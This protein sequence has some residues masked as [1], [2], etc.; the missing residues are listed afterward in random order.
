MKVLSKQMTRAVAAGA[1]LLTTLAGIQLVRRA[2]QRRAVEAL[3]AATQTR[4][5][6]LSAFVREH[7]AALEMLAHNAGTN[8][9][10][11]AA[12]AGQVNAATLRDIFQNESYWQPFREA[13]RD[14]YLALPGRK[15]V[16]IAGKREMDL[17]A[18][19]LVERASQS[20][21]VTS[22]LLEVGGWV[23]AVVAVPVTL[24]NVPQVPVLLLLQPFDA[25]A[26][27]KLVERTGEAVVMSNGQQALLGA[28]SAAQTALLKSAIG[29]ETVSAGQVLST[30]D[31]AVAAVP[32]GN[33]LW[34]LSHVAEA[35]GAAGAVYAVL[36][37]GTGLLGAVI[38]LLL[39][40]GMRRR[41]LV[42]PDG[43][44]I[45]ATVTEVSSGSR[46]V[47]LKRLG[48]GGAAEV[49]LAVS[50]G[51]RGFRRP[52]VVKRLRPE[53]SRD[54]EAM[55]QFTDE[56]TLA[57]SLVH[58][59]I[60]PIYD[61]ARYADQYFLVEEYIVGRDFGRL[62]RAAREAKMEVPAQVAAHVVCETLKALDYAHNKRDHDG[63]P[64]GIVH[65]DVSPEN[66]MVNTRG[67]VQLLDFGVL[68]SGARGPTRRKKE[69]GE[70]RGNLT[71]MAPEQAKGE[72]VDARAD[73]Y[74]LGLV[75]YYGLTGESLYGDE[76]TGYDL[77]MNAA[78]GPGLR[79]LAKL[80][81]LPEPY[82]HILR[83]ALAPNPEHRYQSATAFLEALAPLAGD[84]RPR[85]G[86]M[87]TQLFG[88]ELE[89]ERHQLSGTAT[90]AKPGL[91]GTREFEPLPP[92][93]PT[94]RRIHV[95][96]GDPIR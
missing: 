64:L 49:H 92:R 83:K 42:A 67:D 5:Q 59:N 24:P 60:V 55:A 62:L 70:L 18:R 34:L 79:E 86:A 85:L 44:V 51:E 73:L 6:E 88:E 21:F 7:L 80:D 74:S 43:P 90:G 2:E 76:V 47:L 26:I 87:V 29:R 93:G 1:V 82:S 20:R 69:M 46:Y 65:R 48:G 30:A 11:V 8:P 33:D 27:D 32:L 81:R 66:V 89:E 72:E 31:A 9:R 78:S 15:P 53:L 36:A 45:P 22:S 84:V 94:S 35:A 14:T 38:F 91:P 13:F 17:E 4:T 41:A 77:L 75:L 25:A 23:E 39:L 63:A 54:A 3:G 16:F 52:C 10:L 37:I 50:M 95:V 96:G 68:K 40:F 58:A 71:F 57:S 56:A 61:F 12:L 19:A 28:G